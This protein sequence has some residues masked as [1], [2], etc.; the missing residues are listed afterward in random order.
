MSWD[1]LNE[2]VAEARAAVAAAAPDPQTAAEGDAYVL[3]V[4]VTV[5]RLNNKAYQPTAANQGNV[6]VPAA[7]PAADTPQRRR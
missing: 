2:A 5:G 3:R 7:R 1:A 6:Q 4:A